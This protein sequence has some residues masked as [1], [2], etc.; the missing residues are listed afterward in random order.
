MLK[1]MDRA[2]PRCSA[3]IS[4]TAKF[5]PRC[6]TDVATVTTP[7]AGTTDLRDPLSPRRK[8]LR[9]LIVGWILF[10]AGGVLGLAGLLSISGMRGWIVFGVGLSVFMTG[11]GT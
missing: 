11:L 5:C 7:S 2:C 8:A 10:V 4:A 1:L 3:P 6:G 9:E